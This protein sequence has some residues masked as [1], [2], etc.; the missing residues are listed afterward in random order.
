M[1]P[2]FA[3]ERSSDGH[4]APRLAVVLIALLA[5]SFPP[6]V[7]A[8]RSVTLLG[9]SMTKRPITSLEGIDVS[10]WQGSINWS[11]VATTGKKFAFIRASAGS[12]TVD[13]TY[14]ANRAGAKAAG[15][16]IGAYHYGNPDN[17]VNDALNEANWFLSL[18]TPATGELR[19]ALDIEVANGLSPAALQTWVASWLARVTSVTGIKPIIYSTPSFWK[20]HLADSSWFAQNGYTVLWIAHWQVKSPSVPAANWAGY[21]W[22]FW[23]YS[24]CGTVSGIVGCVDLDRYNG[25]A[26]ASSLFMP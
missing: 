15:L 22:T 1:S 6:A 13:T 10:M 24:D 23:Q 14:T 3:S 11:R 5:L 25:S 18:A 20:D 7:A 21:G 9:G 12:L 8:Q 4:S 2:R 17:A 19:P 16:V 26:L